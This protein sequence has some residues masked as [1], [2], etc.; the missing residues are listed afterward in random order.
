MLAQILTPDVRQEIVSRLDLIRLRLKQSAS[1]QQ[2]ARIAALQSFLMEHPGDEIWTI[3]GLTR[4]I[5]QRS[6]KGGLEFFKTSA[7]AL[8]EALGEDQRRDVLAVATEIKKSGLAQNLEQLARKIPGMKKYFTEQVDDLW[9]KGLS[10][11]YHQDLH[12]GLFTQAELEVGYTRLTDFTDEVL[13]Q[14]LE[15]EAEFRPELVV[16]LTQKMI[17]AFAQYLNEQLTPDRLEQMRL[18][19]KTLL[20][21]RLY[22]KAWGAFIL[23]IPERLA[24]DNVVEDEKAF[25]LKAYLGEVQKYRSE[26]DAD[27][28]NDGAD[29][30]EDE[31][32]TVDQVME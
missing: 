9:D 17:A 13:S 12:L 14:S 31:A 8:D 10:A 11:L 18:H 23:A 2:T 5:F 28:D 29:E 26:V 6:L 24:G 19:V 20:K 22:P 4:A 7:K 15:A 16:D 1:P 32:E 27:N 3:T 30:G 21:Q 25:F